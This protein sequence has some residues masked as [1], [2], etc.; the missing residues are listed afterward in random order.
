MTIPKELVQHLWKWES[1][2]YHETPGDPGGP[3]KFGICQRSYPHIDIYNLTEEQAVEIYFNDYWLA[4]ACDTLP[5]PVAILVF[6]GN[7]N[8]GVKRSHKALQK[9]VGAYED[10]VIGPKT[11]ACVNAVALCSLPQLLKDVAAARASAYATVNGELVER[12]SYGWYRRLFECY[13]I[14]TY[15]MLELEGC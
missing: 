1:T 11:L 13:E 14:A 7:V 4:G 10:G 5:F 15:R 3:T 6:D 2:K 8:Q 9:A 12:F